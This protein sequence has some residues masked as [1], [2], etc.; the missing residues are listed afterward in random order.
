[1]YTTRPKSRDTGI[2]MYYSLHEKQVERGQ[3]RRLKGQPSS[4]VV[5]LAKHI[6]WHFPRLDV[7]SYS[8]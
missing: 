6:R 1:M 2:T 7:A 8:G 4:L 3:D 5:K